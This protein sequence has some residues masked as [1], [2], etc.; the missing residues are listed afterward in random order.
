MRFLTP[1]IAAFRYWYTCATSDDFGVA[2]STQIVTL[3]MIPAAFGI[4]SLFY[5]TLRLTISS[6][7]S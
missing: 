2:I 7:W 1:W 5:M 3:L 4:L 6:W